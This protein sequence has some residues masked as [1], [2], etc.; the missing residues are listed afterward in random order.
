[1]LLS[2]S[3]YS[4]VLRLLADMSLNMLIIRLS[5]RA[6]AMSYVMLL[7]LLPYSRLM[8]CRRIG[9]RFGLLADGVSS[10]RAYFSRLYDSL[11]A[12]W[13]LLLMEYLDLT[14]NRA[15]LIF[16]FSSLILMISFR[17]LR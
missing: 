15:F 2:A 5:P 1:M 10:R 14:E 11:W 6:S 8:A 9:S 7:S 3:S 13:V 17:L 12:T 4:S 16:S